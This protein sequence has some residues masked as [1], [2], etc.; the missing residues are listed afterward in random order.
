MSLRAVVSPQHRT[1]RSAIPTRIRGDERPMNA[2]CRT[3]KAKNV[4][5]R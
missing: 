4:T 5:E 3:L 2:K 1:A